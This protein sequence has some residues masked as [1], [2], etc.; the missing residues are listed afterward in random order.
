MTGRC[1]NCGA[2]I[3][4][5]GQLAAAQAA[6][7][8]VRAHEARGLCTQCY[9]KAV[10]Y[11]RRGEFPQTLNGQSELRPYSARPGGGSA[12]E[13]VTADARAAALTCA[14]H[15]PADGLREVLNMLGLIDTQPTEAL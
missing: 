15:V 2:T 12:A 3:V 8:A 13:V 11:G 5:Q 4:P 9:G 10:H 14:R 6:G 7:L 1:A